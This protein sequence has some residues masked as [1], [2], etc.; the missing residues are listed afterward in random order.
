M[1]ATTTPGFLRKEL[2]W[3]VNFDHLDVELNK[4][5]IIQRIIDFGTWDE[6][7]KMVK[8]YG[9]NSVIKESLKNRELSAHGAS[10]ISHYFNK[11]IE[12]FICYKRR[13]SSPEPFHF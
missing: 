9:E 2:F 13:Q 10:F 1:Q 3:D 7:L 5:L 4:S 12:E 11:D 8:F 6:F